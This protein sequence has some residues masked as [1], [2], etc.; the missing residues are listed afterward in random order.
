MNLNA[1][2]PHYWRQVNDKFDEGI[3]DM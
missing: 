1:T 3:L 2:Q